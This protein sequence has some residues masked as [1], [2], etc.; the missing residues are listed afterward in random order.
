MGTVSTGV[1]FN[2]CAAA[3]ATAV[4]HAI[5]SAVNYKLL[6]AQR[7]KAPASNDLF[8]IRNNRFRLFEIAVE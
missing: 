8:R 4:Q 5:F 2:K 6:F 3:V 1:A 7:N